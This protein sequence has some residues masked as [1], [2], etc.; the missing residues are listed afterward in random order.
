MA[1]IRDRLEL[2]KKAGISKTLI[3]VDVFALFAYQ[4]YHRRYRQL[5]NNVA[6]IDIGASQTTVCL[7]LGERP[8]IVRTI[9]WGSDSLTQ[10]IAERYGCSGVEAEQR[11]R[12]TDASHME[13]FLCPLVDELR[14]TLH[15][16]ERSAKAA[17][18]QHLLL[19][20][21]GSLLGGLRQYLARELRL[22]PLSMAAPSSVACPQEFAVAFGAA[23]P[24]STRPYSKLV[25][26]RSAAPA[27][28]AIDFSRV[29]TRSRSRLQWMKQ[30]L[31]FHGIGIC[32]IAV[33]LF[34]DLSIRV[35]LAESRVSE[36]K[37]AVQEQ[38]RRQFPGIGSGQ[39]DL[40]QARLALESLKK[41]LAELGTDRPSILQ[42]LTGLAQAMPSPLV[43]K[44]TMLTIEANAI[45]LEAEAG[46]FESV[47][48]VKERVKTLPRL[49]DAK[50]SDARVGAMPNQVMFRL[51]L[52]F[53][54]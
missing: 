41:G 21:G 31:L 32:L 29:T 20:G 45:H 53:E 28:V 39:E 35:F 22:V 6:V 49:L 18:I 2:S 1:H 3:D 48:R 19:C 37:A 34:A 11:K 9:D 16:Y 8:S 26:S 15:G 33:L 36:L 43:Q 13:S 38:M 30:H 44:V 27:I 24:A 51:A 50:V 25:P 40:D 54:N 52:T 23:V 17:T 7:T 4:Q 46:S 5:P 42:I 14:L 12:Q 10:A 47:E